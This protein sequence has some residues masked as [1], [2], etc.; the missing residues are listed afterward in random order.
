MLPSSP[1]ATP[2]HS[3]STTNPQNEEGKNHSHR[4]RVILACAH[5]QIFAHSGRHITRGD[6]TCEGEAAAGVHGEGVDEARVDYLRPCG[7]QPAGGRVLRREHPALGAPLSLLG[8]AVTRR[9][10]KRDSDPVERLGS[11]DQQR[12]NGRGHADGIGRDE[13]GGPDELSDWPS[14]LAVAI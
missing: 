6:V 5:S 7:S 13:R 2:P 3:T 4:G 12:K 10:S 8:S 11:R 14:R 1:N 9:D